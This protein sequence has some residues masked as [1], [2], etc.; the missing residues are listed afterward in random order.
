MHTAEKK[1]LSIDEALKTQNSATNQEIKSKFVDQHV[2]ANI[3][4]MVNFILSAEHDHEKPFSYDDIENYY[5]F[6]EYNDDNISFDGGDE[7]D[8]QEAIDEVQALIDA[9]AD[10]LSNLDDVDIEGLSDDQEASHDEIYAE[11]EAIRDSLEATLEELE[12]LESKPQEI[13]EYW[14]VSSYLCKKLS[15]YGQPTIDGYIWGRC[16]S[17]QA[18]LLDYVIGKIC[19]DMEILEGQQHSWTK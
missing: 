18:I 6:D 7:D 11:Q 4:N 14:H 8:K 12:N 13:L 2:N 5:S 17:G 10:E 16:T 15:A 1:Y 3:N 9:N 19:A